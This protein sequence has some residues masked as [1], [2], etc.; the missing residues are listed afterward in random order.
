MLVVWCSEPGLRDARLYK[1][2]EVPDSCLII[3]EEET[4]NKKERGF[5]LADSFWVGQNWLGWVSV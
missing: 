1:T 3:L 5:W 4:D 2:N